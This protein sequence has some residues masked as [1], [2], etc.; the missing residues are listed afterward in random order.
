MRNITLKWLE[1]QDA[2]KEGI[3]WFK[4]QSERNDLKIVEKLIA[5]NKLDWANWLIVRLM[6]YKQYVS[7]AIYSAEQVIHIY[8]NKYP[9]DKRPR[10]AIKAAKKCIKSPTKKNK[11]AADTARAAA[12]A[13]AF[14]AADSADAAARVAAASYTA[15]AAS[16]SAASAARAAAYTASYAASA[17]STSVAIRIKI[18]NYG[19][20]II[21]KEK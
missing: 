11:Q 18:L 16:T 3:E 7:Y 9:C 6:T 2:C 21:K 15:S 13:A 19:I 5:E 20:K 4:N 17:A 1:K 12:D 10:N 14:A 8:E